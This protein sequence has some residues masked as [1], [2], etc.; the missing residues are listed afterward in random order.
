[1]PLT[2]LAPPYPIFTDK[3]GDPLDAGY[4]YFGTANL[5]PETNPIQVYYDSALTQPAAQPIRTINGY[6][7]RNGSPALIYAN[8]QFSVTVRDKNN[9]LVIYSPVGYGITPG[10]SATS[11]DQIT[12][13]EGSTGAVTRVL[14]ARLQDYVSV[15]DFGAVGDGVAD[16]TVAIQAAINSGSNKVIIPE[17]RYRTT[18]SIIIPSDV[19]VEGAGAGTTV[20]DCQISSIPTPT[21]RI[22][23]SSAFRFSGTCADDDYTTF[24]NATGDYFISSA[25]PFAAASTFAA[26]SNTITAANS[27][28][29]SDL[30][31]G[32]WVHISEGLPTWHPAKSE[33]ARVASVVGTT[34]TLGQRLRNLYSNTS[35][36]L[37][38]FIR[39]YSLTASPGGGGAGYPNMS[40]WE[41]SGFRKVSPTVNAALRNL[42]IECNQSGGISPIASFSH[43]AVNF[44]V[45]VEIKTGVFWK[46][47]SQDLDIRVRGGTAAARDSY[48]GNGC[49]SIVADIDIINS[50]S[51]EEGAQNVSGRVRTIGYSKIKA[52]ASNITLDVDI[53][54]NSA[55]ALE[56]STC[57]NVTLKPTLRSNSNAFNVTTPSLTTVAPDLP[58]SFLSG[59][60][61]QYYLTSPI[62]LGG[63]CISSSNPAL[64]V[65]FQA[66]LCARLIDV[67]VPVIPT[68]RFK[69]SCVINGAQYLQSIATFPAY[70]D[71]ENG[72]EFISTAYGAV[73]VLGQLSTTTFSQPAADKIIV[74]NITTGGDVRPGDIVIFRLSDAAGTVTNWSWHVA[75]VSNVAIASKV[76]QFSPA[77]AGSRFAITGDPVLFYRVSNRFAQP[78]I[79]TINHKAA[80]EYGEIATYSI[81]YGGP[82]QLGSYHIWVDTSG[83]LRIKNGV[84]TSETDGTVVGTQT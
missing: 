71:L 47:D 32:D 60:V 54:A 17:G 15:K 5:N 61:P 55:P 18:A 42:T 50:I 39:D 69:G 76:V 68:K 52:F 51:I 70:S 57:R 23:K 13:N 19:A 10:T 14:T 43:I 83:R 78:A 84:P 24:Y 72:E 63:E 22:A 37:G 40:T 35:T 33:F 49:N 12:Y 56:Y 29:V 82:L 62:L 45:D 73:Q 81:K 16:D 44:S 1:M 48:L 59:E 26:G 74:N 28:D 79:K 31:A 21:E 6:P 67:V 41:N 20:I 30:Q 7:S 77:I 8:A 53:V 4:L 64:S 11:T 2:Q 36:S 38:Q 80:S 3:N 58:S 9:A 27:S 34:I 25:R 75:E 46:I 65:D 66:D